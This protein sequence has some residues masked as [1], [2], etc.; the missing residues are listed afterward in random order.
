[1]SLV[2]SIVLV[3]CV[4]VWIFVGIMLAESAIFEAISVCV[5]VCVF[6]LVSEWRSI[7][8]PQVKITGTTL[9]SE[10]N[11]SLYDTGD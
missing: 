7:P 6:I 10:G 5:C 1:M 4:D 9:F 11:I 8:I 2:F 3:A